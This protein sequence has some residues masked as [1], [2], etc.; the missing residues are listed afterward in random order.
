MDIIILPH[1]GSAYEERVEYA[2]E[3]D[4]EGSWP[5]P[6][7]FGDFQLTVLKDP[8]R[9]GPVIRHANHTVLDKHG[10]QTS[11]QKIYWGV[12]GRLKVQLNPKHYNGP[13]MAALTRQPPAVALK[14]ELTD[15]QKQ[16]RKETAK[17]SR[18][19]RKRKKAE[20]AAA[21]AAA[22]S[23]VVIAHE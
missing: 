1:G 6:L 23:T 12:D 10:E 19:R 11:F 7:V 14:R 2:I 16:K 18:E 9:G 3:K 17:A 8:K 20:E 21:A 22:A 4:G 5:A 15:D 13:S